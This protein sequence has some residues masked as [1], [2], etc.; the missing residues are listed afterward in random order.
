MDDGRKFGLPHQMDASETLEDA[1]GAIKT[2][3]E[4]LLLSNADFTPPTD[5]SVDIRGQEDYVA[6]AFSCGTLRGFA[7][8][9][10]L[11]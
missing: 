1:N 4:T 5:V 9:L 11:I 8:C 10:T 6:S 7:R 3:S 2:T